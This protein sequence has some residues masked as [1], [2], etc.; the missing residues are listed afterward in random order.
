MNLLVTNLLS[1]IWKCLNSP[2]ICW[3]SLEEEGAGLFLI[4]S[5]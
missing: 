3:N 4:S 1:L 2:P 5:K